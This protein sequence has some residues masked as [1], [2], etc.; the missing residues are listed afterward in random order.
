MTKILVVDDS[1]S[2]RNLISAY[3]SDKGYQVIA[4]DNAK[5]AIKKSSL[6]KP[7]VIITDVVMP[8]MNGY[9][10]C[11]QLKKLPETKNI[12]IVICTSKDQKIDRFWG[13]KS[14]ADV[15]LIKPVNQDQITRAVE[16]L[17]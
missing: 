9:E 10:L 5:E 2:E 6:Q 4:A 11:R 1:R 7:D 3:L 16:S 15:Y 8:G 17:I 12:R 14:G 13:M